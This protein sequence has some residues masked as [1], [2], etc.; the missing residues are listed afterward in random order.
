MLS[1]SIHN[2]KEGYP[3][4]SYEITVDHTKRIIAATEAHSRVRNDKT[5]VKFDSFV[6]HTHEG[7]LYGD[8]PSEL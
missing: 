7:K 2:G 5:I 1:W 3:T 4:L 6:N 8:V